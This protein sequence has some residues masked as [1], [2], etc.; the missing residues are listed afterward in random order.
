MNG[1]KGYPKRRHALNC[2]R[3]VVRSVLGCDEQGFEGL[4]Y[5]SSS[6]A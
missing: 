1:P 5:A 6:A 4:E 2:R 3:P